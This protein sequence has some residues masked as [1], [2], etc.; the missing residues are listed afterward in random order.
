MTQGNMPVHRT[1]NR[2]KHA[3][4]KKNFVFPSATP[5]IMEQYKNAGRRKGKKLKFALAYKL[6]SSRI[7]MLA[8]REN[9]GERK[10]L[11][12]FAASLHVTVIIHE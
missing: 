10:I 11:T 4:I 9:I 1:G 5:R 12:S 7:T 6:M 3:P 8:E 2:S